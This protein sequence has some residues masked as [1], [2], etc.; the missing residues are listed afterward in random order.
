MQG[1][2][3]GANQTTGG[4]GGTGGVGGDIGS[5]GTGA[6]PTAGITFLSG[7]QQSDPVATATLQDAAIAIVEIEAQAGGRL[8][9]SIVKNPGP[10]VAATYSCADFSLVSYFSAGVEFSTRPK[11]GKCSVVVESFGGVNKPLVG[12]FSATLVDSGGAT[13]MLT[14]GRFNI[15]V[16]A[17][18]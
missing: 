1:G 17:R 8:L 18:P 10:F 9:L 3:G 15:K 14:D 16:E 12:S 5:G 4:T 11:S 6:N 7:V 2:A 13:K